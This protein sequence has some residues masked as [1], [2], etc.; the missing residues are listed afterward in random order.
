MAAIPPGS[1]GE[2]LTNRLEL[3]GPSFWAP[4]AAKYSRFPAF[5]TDCF[6]IYVIVL[7]SGKATQVRPP[8]GG[9]LAQMC[10]RVNALRVTHLHT[11]HRL[12]SL[13]GERTCADRPTARTH[14]RLVK[15]SVITDCGGG[16]AP[17]KTRPFFFIWGNF[18]SAGMAIARPDRSSEN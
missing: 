14:N 5:L 18:I 6:S 7:P 11:H 3:T 4:I 13:C 2:F 10:E 8:A 9:I 1:S 15:L 12:I 16:G 17:A